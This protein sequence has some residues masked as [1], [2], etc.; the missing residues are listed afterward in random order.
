MMSRAVGEGH[1]RQHDRDFDK[2]ADDRGERRAA[3]QSEQADG[4]GY[5]K[6]EEV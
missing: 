1:E 6:L 2:D 4:Y 5:R 3:V